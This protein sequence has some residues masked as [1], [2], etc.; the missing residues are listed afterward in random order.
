MQVF[1]SQVESEIFK[2]NQ[3]SLHY[4]KI[5]KKEWRALRSLA[6]GRSIFIKKADKVLVLLCGI[7]E[8]A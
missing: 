7:G 1:L 6:K 3:N 4:F 8:I 2:E 5:S